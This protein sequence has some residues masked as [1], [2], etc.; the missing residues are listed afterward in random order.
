MKQRDESSYVFF[1]L[2]PY[3]HQ[4]EILED[5]RL[6]R[7]EYNSYRNLVVAATGERVIIVTGCNIYYKTKDFRNFKQI[8]LLILKS[9]S[10]ATYQYILMSLVLS[11]RPIVEESIF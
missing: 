7:E 1:D 8:S 11:S 4:R 9:L 2:R 10:V 5:L 6:E 3:S